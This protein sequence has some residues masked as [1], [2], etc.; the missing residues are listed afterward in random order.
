MK[1]SAIAFARGARIGVRMI[2]MSVPPKTA[3]AAVYLVSRPRIT[4]RNGS[5]RLPKANE[6]VAGLLGNPVGR[7]TIPAM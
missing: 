3:N 5:A 6:Q 7:A 2:R 1:H 4:N